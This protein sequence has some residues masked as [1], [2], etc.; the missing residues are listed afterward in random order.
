ME[1][2]IILGRICLIWRLYLNC[3]NLK[4]SMPGL[5]KTQIIGGVGF[6]LILVSIPV[7][8]SLAKESQIFRSQASEGKTTSP[9]TR[10]VNGTVTKPRPVPSSS[11]L[12]ELQKLLQGGDT[13]GTTDQIVSPTPT[14]DVNLAF[15]P[16][17]NLSVATE[18]RPENMQSGKVFIG[19]ALN[20]STIPP[21]FILTFTVNMPDSGIFKGISLAGLN[22]GSVYTAFVKGESQIDTASTFT[23]SPTE[24]N[25]GSGE[26]VILLSGDLNEDNTITAADYTITRN[27]Y[28]TTT[29]SNNWNARADFN[30]DG[31]INNYDL[32]YINK[33][34]GKIGASGT[35]ISSP[36]SSTP[37]A[38]LIT[39]PNIGGPPAG[40]A[41]PPASFGD[42][43]QSSSSSAQNESYS[44]PTSSYWLY[45][46]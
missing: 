7:S 43:M 28:G 34:M 41:G 31:V 32:M 33:N 11:P 14:P 5:T 10:S 21:K 6:L 3:A 13:N 35:W 25:L 36:K 26:P 19:I 16:T 22:P 1:L 4:I 2:K 18:G 12:S 30:K 38:A 24:S 20:S 27:L 44:S 45:V 39:K 15:G 23:M 46:P 8:F 9:T 37:S 42:L 17:L 29:F 40:E